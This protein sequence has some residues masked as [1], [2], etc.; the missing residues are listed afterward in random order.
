MPVP[1]YVAIVSRSF[2]KE[3][4]ISG[5]YYHI[6]ISG[7][8]FS[9]IFIYNIMHNKY[10]PLI[11]TALSFISLGISFICLASGLKKY[12]EYQK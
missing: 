3:T 5:I 10:S 9:G 11:L 7:I 4:E 8:I 12:E 1:I 6:S 2:F